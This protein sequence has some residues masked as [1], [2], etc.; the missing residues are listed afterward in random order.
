M[1]WLLRAL[2]SALGHAA[3]SSQGEVLPVSFCGTGSTV[4]VQNCILFVS[5]DHS[6]IQKTLHPLWL[7]DDNL[8]F[9][10]SI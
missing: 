2:S 10:S 4:L 9:I 7:T 5:G 1:G 8:Q 6:L 3:A